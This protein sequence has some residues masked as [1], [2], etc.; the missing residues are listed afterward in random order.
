M[1]LLVL[2]SWSTFSIFSSL[3]MIFLLPNKS[4]ATIQTLNW[5]KKSL[6]KFAYK[7]IFPSSW[8][9]SSLIDTTVFVICFG[10]SIAM[11]RHHLNVKSRTFQ[12]LAVMRS[13]TVKSFIRRHHLLSK[14]WSGLRIT[15][16]SVT[17]VCES[18]G[19][20]HIVHCSVACSLQLHNGNFSWS[21]HGVQ[22]WCSKYAQSK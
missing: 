16:R 4:V 2:V 14:L 19:Q 1:W 5:F 6:W 13:Q 7:C 11:W 15:F 21:S 3:A 9:H 12:T 8:C 17:Y 10:C 20:G 22:L 18:V